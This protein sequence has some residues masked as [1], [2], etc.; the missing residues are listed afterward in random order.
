LDTDNKSEFKENSVSDDLAL[1]SQ[2]SQP[3]DSDQI[4]EPELTD[5]ERKKLNDF[6][7][8]LCKLGM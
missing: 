6:Y 7:N 1:S 5:E 2:T 3:L 4:E 8:E